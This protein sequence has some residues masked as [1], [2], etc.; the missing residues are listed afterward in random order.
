MDDA[1]LAEIEI[2]RALERSIEATRALLPSRPRETCIDCGE[3][4]EPHRQTW[5]ICI[6]CKMKRERRQHGI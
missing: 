3:D 2:E 5:G 6:D 4:L 1:D